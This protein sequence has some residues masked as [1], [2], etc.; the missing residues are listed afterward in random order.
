MDSQPK[1]LLGM[2]STANSSMMG[3]ESASSSTPMSL[4]NNGYR[5]P[6][7]AMAVHSMS[8][9]ESV[10]TSSERPTLSS[11]STHGALEEGANIGMNS[12][13]SS[14]SL[15]IKRGVLS[16]IFRKDSESSNDMTSSSVSTSSPDSSSSSSVGSDL[17]QESDAQ[18]DVYRRRRGAY[19]RRG[20]ESHGSYGYDRPQYYPLP[21]AYEIT[22]TTTTTPSPAL[23]CI[24]DGQVVQLEN[25]FTSC[26]TSTTTTTAASKFDL[27][28]D[29]LDHKPLDEGLKIPNLFHKN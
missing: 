5:Y 11:N 20:Y 3:P 4:G 15:R 24:V 28:H 25:G 6:F 22:T 17:K 21:C 8:G 7:P 23:I 14:A 26:P 13:Q 9:N 27:F 19:S 29:K 18:P 10:P 1:A 16:S 12:T 2:N